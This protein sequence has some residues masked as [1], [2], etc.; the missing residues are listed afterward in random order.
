MDLVFEAI[1]KVIDDSDLNL[2]VYSDSKKATDKTFSLVVKNEVSA[3]DTKFKVFDKETK[4]R[5]G[6]YNLITLRDEDNIV[7][8]SINSL[9]NN[10]SRVIVK[11]DKDS[12][13]V[14]IDRPFSHEIT[15]FDTLTLSIFDSLRITP[16]SMGGK[17][18]NGISY[19]VNKRYI[20]RLYTKND[21]S[22]EKQM[23][24]QEELILLFAKSYIMRLDEN[25]EKTK[26]TIDIIDYLDWNPLIE[27]EDDAQ[28]VQGSMRILDR[29]NIMF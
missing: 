26:S 29:K 1:K 6:K 3:I 21:S 20:F 27:N 19:E 9:L 2:Y 15:E 7:G 13:I 10:E 24:Y 17:N 11:Y 4:D 18:D 25:L 28:V 23:Q 12:G 22:R 8:Y 16:L 5:Y 14:E